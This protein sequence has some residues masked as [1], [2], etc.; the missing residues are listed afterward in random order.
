MFILKTGARRN[1]KFK[2]ATPEF[3]QNLQIIGRQ[4][5]PGTV[6]PDTLLGGDTHY[7]LLSGIGDVARPA[8]RTG[9]IRSNAKRCR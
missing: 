4:I 7:Y 5:Y 1:F 8:V 9:V 2:L 6:F 3:I